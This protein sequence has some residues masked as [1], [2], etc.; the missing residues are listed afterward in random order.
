[1]S[2]SFCLLDDSATDTGLRFRPEG[3]D[4]S[5]FQANPILLYM[6]QRGKVLGRWNNV[7]LKG[8]KW[9]GTPEFDI[10]DPEAANLAGK[11]ERGFL[12][13]C[14]MG[15]Y[16][17]EVQELE[18]QYWVTRWEAQE[19]S[20][21]DVGSNANS[22]MLMSATGE[23][24]KDT[25]TYIQHLT[26][27]SMEKNQTTA[28]EAAKNL[29]PKSLALA[30]G[31]AETAT[32]E[33]VETKVLTLAASNATLTKEKGELEAKVKTLE[34]AAETSKTSQIKDLLDQ[35]VADKKID[36][37]ERPHYEKLAAV[38]IDTV[39]TIIGKM[40]PPVDLVKLA[41]NGAKTNA[42]E[43]VSQAEEYEKLFKANKLVELKASDPAKFK[44]LYKAKYGVEPKS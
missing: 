10:E 18:G 29:F 20:I 1:M 38:D 4:M 17:H 7:E 26:L 35:A 19:C 16:V 32:A 6:H 41:A 15:V 24:I 23:A 13:A 33:E 36:A 9:Y 11:V 5:R 28:A 43:A 40:A 27:S 14:S 44:A 31:L 34:L 12:R 25:A 8:G 30:A 37:T 22:I 21:V 42:T 2:K 3:G 39:R